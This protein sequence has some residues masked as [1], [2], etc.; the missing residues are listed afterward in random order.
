MFE[1][2]IDLVTNPVHYTIEKGMNRKAIMSSHFTKNYTLIR[3]CSYNRV[4]QAIPLISWGFVS[5]ISLVL[6][7]IMWDR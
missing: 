6:V 4:K 3:F 7:L 2:R 5:R 1:H